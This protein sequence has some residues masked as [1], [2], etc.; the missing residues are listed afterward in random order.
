MPTP[1]KYEGPAARQRAYRDRANM[2]RLAE[3]ELKGLPCAPAIPSMP[4]RARWRAMIAQAGALLS[5]AEREIQ[6]YIDDRSET[7]QESE[8]AES[9]EMFRQTIQEVA[10]SLQMIQI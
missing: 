7:W 8:R 9:L 6:N 2:A 4:S 1:R 10:D 3:R 5:A